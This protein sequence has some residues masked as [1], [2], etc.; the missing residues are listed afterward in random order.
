MN[1]ARQ[2]MDVGI[3]AFKM[4]AVLQMTHAVDTVL[5]RRYSAHFFI[6]SLHGGGFAMFGTTHR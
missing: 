4:T 6:E 5:G 2:A 1:I 3:L